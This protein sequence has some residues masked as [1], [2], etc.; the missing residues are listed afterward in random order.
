MIEP[1]SLS[2]GQGEDT[3]DL[4]TQPQN[5]AEDKVLTPYSSG[6]GQGVEQYPLP[7]DFNGTEEQDPSPD[8]SDEE[9]STDS[10][11]HSLLHEG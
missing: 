4:T 10:S 5:T 7:Y 1:P 3:E 6:V 2:A 8:R 11:T 9:D